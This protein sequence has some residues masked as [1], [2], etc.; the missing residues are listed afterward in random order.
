MQVALVFL[1]L[2]D[3]LEVKEDYLEA[4]EFLRKVVLL[5]EENNEEHNISMINALLRLGKASFAFCL[6]KGSCLQAR[7]ANCRINIDQQGSL[8]SRF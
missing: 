7:F 2:A 5:Y 6:F 8:M 3:F 4:E 1:N